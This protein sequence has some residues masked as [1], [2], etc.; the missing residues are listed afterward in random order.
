MIQVW[1]RVQRMILL[2]YLFWKLYEWESCL[3]VMITHTFVLSNYTKFLTCALGWCYTPNSN[4][5]LDVDLGLN[6]LSFLVFNWSSLC[7]I[8]IFVLLIMSMNK[9]MNIMLATIEQ[10]TIVLLAHRLFMSH[11]V[12]TQKHLRDRNNEFAFF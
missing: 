4:Y 8:K 1:N 9:L 7:R 2:I 12:E 6:F 11:L 3:V 10:L 5:T